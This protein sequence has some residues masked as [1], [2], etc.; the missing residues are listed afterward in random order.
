MI[1][2]DK[3][4]KRKLFDNYRMKLLVATMALI[5]TTPTIQIINQNGNGNIFNVA[6][7]QVINQD[8]EA[9]PKNINDISNVIIPQ[10]VIFNPET[11]QTLEEGATVQSV[12]SIGMN[13]LFDINATNLSEGD[14]FEVSLPTPLDYS[15]I[16]MLQYAKDG[17]RFK[18]EIRDDK[19]IC[20]LLALPTGIHQVKAINFQL[21]APFKTEESSGDITLKTIV[22]TQEVAQTITVHQVA[23]RDISNKIN[24]LTLDLLKGVDQIVQQDELINPYE[25][26]YLNMTID[27]GTEMFSNQVQKGDY[28]DI[29]LPN[30]LDY[31]FVQDLDYDS[32][33][34]KFHGTIN[35][36]T[37]I[38]HI[39]V[40][41]APR[42]EG[43]RIQ[44]EF[45]VAMRFDLEKVKALESDAEGKRKMSL[46]INT[47]NDEKEAYSHRFILQ[48]LNTEHENEFDYYIPPFK[49][50][51]T[52]S[53]G[54]TP[55]SM[56]DYLD[57]IYQ[58]SE[59]GYDCRGTQ[60]NFAPYEIFTL[61]KLKQKYV[62]DS[63]VNGLKKHWSAGPIQTLDN[64]YTSLPNADPSNYL[65]GYCIEEKGFSHIRPGLGLYAGRH[66]IKVPLENYNW[67][68]YEQDK[69]KLRNVVAHC[70]PFVS[71][72]EMRQYYHLPNDIR[73]S[74]MI[75]ATQQVLWD[76]RRIYPNT[77]EEVKYNRKL[78]ADVWTEPH[79][80]G[81]L[82]LQ[83]GLTDEQR[84]LQSDAS[85]MFRA[86]D[87]I[88]SRYT[89]N[90]Q[91]NS[92]SDIAL[93]TVTIKGSTLT[94]S[95][96]R[97]LDSSETGKVIIRSSNGKV[98]QK[99]I[100]MNTP[101]TIS[102]DIASLLTNAQTTI[103]VTLEIVDSDAEVQFYVMDGSGIWTQDL[104]TGELYPRTYVDQA[105]VQLNR[106]KFTF[107]KV[108]ATTKNAI[109]GAEFTLTKLDE[110]GNKTNLVYYESAN[111]DGEFI[112]DELSP[113]EYLLEEIKA[114]EGYLLTGMIF[115]VTIYAD[116]T[117][118]VE[119]KKA[120]SDQWEG[121]SPTID[122]HYQIENPQ[123]VD[124]IIQKVDPEGNPIL[125]TKLRP[126]AEFELKEYKK[127]AST[128]DE[129][130]PVTTD[131]VYTEIIGKDGTL[132][133][134]QLHHGIWYQLRELKAPAGYQKT[135][136]IWDI[137]INH[138]G[139][140]EITSSENPQ[141]VAT[142][143]TITVMNKKNGNLVINKQDSED[144]SIFLPGAIF[145]LTDLQ[146]QEVITSE[147]TDDQGNVTFSDISPGYYRLQEITPPEGYQL[148]H[149]T[150]MIYVNDHGETYLLANDGT[151]E[152]SNSLENATMITPD[153]PLVIT[154]KVN[155]TAI[156][157]ITKVDAK[158]GEL[159]VDNNHKTTARF[160]IT[161]TPNPVAN[162][163]LS[164]DDIFNGQVA[165]LDNGTYTFTNKGKGFETG[166]YYLWEMRAP[167][168]YVTL[169]ETI[170]F[171]IKADGSVIIPS[172]QNEQG[173]YVVDEAHPAYHMIQQSIE[174]GDTPA[175]EIKVKNHKML[176]PRTGGIGSM[177]FYVIG[178]ISMLSAILLFSKSNQ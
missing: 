75:A 113:G 32:P 121:Y 132:R 54:Y 134:G 39:V 2:K 69:V 26:Y 60:D 120:N 81:K 114:P 16:S 101:L 143:N 47:S 64:G 116:G 36:S 149:K 158:T 38:L 147:A 29:Q 156:I 145:G 107:T 150:W 95:I 4:G 92:P 117:N 28:F 168:G 82:T 85:N 100:T 104:I 67:H 86:I 59:F 37:G 80:K 102:E 127:Q 13:L 118:Q 19:L 1:T 110:E 133:F 43:N 89:E 109:A 165:Y 124:I 27:M 125:A 96:S 45:N 70:Y 42:A 90:Y 48:A 49:D 173:E 79:I 78:T 164:S 65:L 15:N 157:K 23:Q 108:D 129:W 40:E 21:H 30:V 56:N 74:D 153:N 167:Q 99:V 17:V 41:R 52:E 33:Q 62:L 5:L 73:L 170:P 44:F 105:E 135:D 171:Y 106:G 136:T 88:K 166:Q 97:H 9:T 176:F 169:T 10:M 178:L 98:I 161:T 138:N 155:A 58:V 131:N 25:H 46:K 177:L 119:V 87:I 112:F 31:K 154:N 172:K 3:R 50:L 142:D 51:F 159:I 8:K 24:T 35:Q 148:S 141:E 126:G 18:G 72:Q 57:D 111:Q 163:D 84:S 123:D 122:N 76:I 55:K 83:W 20:T 94:T 14:Y 91:V 144:A 77:Q 71:E 68:M 174:E 128:D 53:W 7:E 11:K 61:V 140:I 115:K 93:G 146:T 6:A 175:V 137:K 34:L 152:N 139:D 160:G 63:G 66:Y 12:D 130:N 151:E 22:G 162:A 103:T